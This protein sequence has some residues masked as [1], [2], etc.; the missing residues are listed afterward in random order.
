MWET[1]SF[2]CNWLSH[3]V[4]SAKFLFTADGNVLA[5]GSGKDKLLTGD[6]EE[7]QKSP[8]Q[9]ALPPTESISCG[10]NHVI[11]LT[12]LKFFICDLIQIRKF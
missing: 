2:R 4:L 12:S 6:S 8:V 11:A 1:D 5:W 7:P 3:F 10:V 9:I